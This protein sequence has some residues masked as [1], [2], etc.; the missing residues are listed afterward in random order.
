MSKERAAA[1]D[2]ECAA[3]SGHV[4]FLTFGFNIGLNNSFFE[5]QQF[6]SLKT[7]KDERI[8]RETAGVRV[9]TADRPQYDSGTV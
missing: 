2:V 9:L 5:L 1:E 6:P 4:R 3:R 8:K 7:I